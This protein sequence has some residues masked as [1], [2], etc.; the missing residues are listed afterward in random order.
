MW[1]RETKNLKEGFYWY[2]EKWVNYEGEVVINEMPI[3]LDPQG[4]D[5]PETMQIGDDCCG[6]SLYPKDMEKQD[7]WVWDQPITPP[8]FP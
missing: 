5:Y 7:A 4:D 6:P 1:I 2:R 8:N 3:S